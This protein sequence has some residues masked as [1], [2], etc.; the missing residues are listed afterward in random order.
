MF[1]QTRQTAIFYIMWGKWRRRIFVF[2][3]NTAVLL[4]RASSFKKCY[5]LQLLW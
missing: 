1:F 4:H 3:C 5:L 2:G